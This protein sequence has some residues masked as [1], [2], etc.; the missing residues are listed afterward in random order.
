MTTKVTFRVVGIYCYFPYL[1]LPVEPGHTVKEVM[2]AIV[3]A[4]PAFSYFDPNGN[5][6]TMSYN[7][8]EAST[9]PLNTVNPGPAN[10]PRD[11]QEVVGSSQALAW[12][13]Y[14]SVSGKFPGDDTL[15]EIK[16]ANPTFTQPPYNQT[17]L[18]AG[19]QVPSGFSIFNFN[20]TWRLLRLQ[21]S[22]EAA[23]KRAQRMVKA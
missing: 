9:R 12:Q 21:L 7:Y 22:P 11:E 15:Y 19:I 6:V 1:D 23:A 8:S 20:L 5:V 16:I 3:Q 17:P 2:D 13:Y 14:R 4:Q 10:G 18:N